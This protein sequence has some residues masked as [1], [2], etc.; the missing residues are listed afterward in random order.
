MSCTSKPLNSGAS[1]ISL[2]QCMQAG[3]GMR[4]SLHSLYNHLLMSALMR[5]LVYTTAKPVAL[6]YDHAARPAVS[7]PHS[8][9]PSSSSSSLVTN[10]L[11]SMPARHE[12]SWP[13]ACTSPCNSSPTTVHSLI[14]KCNNVNERS[15]SRSAAHRSFFLHSVKPPLSTQILSK[16]IWVS[17]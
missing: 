10:F 3:T 16:P 15:C 9:S 13:D 4:S 6:W 8:S 14:S 7:K 2:S 11:R 1:K 12:A 5:P 17:S